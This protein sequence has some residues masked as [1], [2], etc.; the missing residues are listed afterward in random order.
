MDLRIASIALANN[1]TLLTRNLKDFERIDGL[2]LR[3]WLD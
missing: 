1:G 3:N 2:K